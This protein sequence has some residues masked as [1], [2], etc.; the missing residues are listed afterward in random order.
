[1]LMLFRH[2]TGLG[3][4]NI[5]ALY[6]RDRHGIRVGYFQLGVDATIL[7]GACF[8]LPPARIVLSA[9]GAAVLNLII[10]LN[11]RPGRYVGVS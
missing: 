9:L 11:H 8:V 2:R 3:V 7:L 4:T 5:L 6:P 10:A 1:M